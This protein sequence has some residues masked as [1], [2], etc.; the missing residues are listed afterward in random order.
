MIEKILNIISV[1]V[2]IASV[3]VFAFICPKVVNEFNTPAHT[4]NASV[5]R[6]NVGKQIGYE[7]TAGDAIYFSTMVAGIVVVACG[8]SIALK[9]CYYEA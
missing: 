4:E 3:G 5:R 9:E 6:A 8:A 7:F 2:L 1:I